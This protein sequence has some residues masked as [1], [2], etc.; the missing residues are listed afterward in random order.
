MGAKRLLPMVWRE[1]VASR[2][3]SAGMAISQRFDK[4]GDPCPPRKAYGAP[5]TC[6]AKGLTECRE[7]LSTLLITFPVRHEEAQSAH[8]VQWLSHR[9]EGHEGRRAEPGDELPPS[10]MS[11]KE[12]SEV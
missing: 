8:A 4:A 3:A 6:V 2:K 10:C 5:K 12:H 9:P 11:G 1:Q 7:T